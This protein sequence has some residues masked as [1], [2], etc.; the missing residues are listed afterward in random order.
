MNLKKRKKKPTNISKTQVSNSI[1]NTKKKK[2]VSYLACPKKSKE[3]QEDRKIIKKLKDTEIRHWKM[4]ECQ[5]FLSLALRRNKET[6]GEDTKYMTKVLY[7]Q[8]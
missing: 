5:S 3:T 8:Y 1:T 4:A 6:E 2:R 7:F